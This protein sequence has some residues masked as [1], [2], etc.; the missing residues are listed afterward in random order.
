MAPLLGRREGLH[1]ISSGEESEL[2]QMAPRTVQRRSD[3]DDA[4]D[5]AARGAYIGR[6]TQR[7]RTETGG[8][9]DCAGDV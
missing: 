1:R 2:A 8:A 5:L 4:A 6:V 9:T 7:A 3:A